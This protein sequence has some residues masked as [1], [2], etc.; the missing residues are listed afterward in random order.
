MESLLLARQRSERTS[1][2]KTKE[3][4]GNEES[5]F[6][7]WEIWKLNLQTW[8][9]KVETSNLKL[10]TAIS[11]SSLQTASLQTS[12]L[13]TQTANC[14]SSNG[15]RR[16]KIESSYFKLHTVKAE[17]LQTSSLQTVYGDL[18]LSLQTSI[19][20]LELQTTKVRNFKLES[21]NCESYES[22]NFKVVET[23][24]CDSEKSESW[25]FKLRNPE[26]ETSNL[27]F[28]VG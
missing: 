20:K 11:D 23:A 1:S 26:F 18:R 6:G 22:S 10:E 14:E 16:S 24:N 9:F 17:N 7:K 28:K 19:F 4:K 12:K 21:A 25:V 3:T 15:I 8:N 5:N 13:Q 27:N 2:E